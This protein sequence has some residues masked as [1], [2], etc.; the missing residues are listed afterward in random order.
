MKFGSGLLVGV[1]Y[2]GV[3]FSMDFV[4]LVL[5]RFDRRGGGVDCVL[6]H[7]PSEVGMVTLSKG[8][9][10]GMFSGDV[11]SSGIIPGVFSVVTR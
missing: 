7:S 4:I 11:G 2:V 3:E 1:R 9:V 5:S 8:C 6:G 10:N